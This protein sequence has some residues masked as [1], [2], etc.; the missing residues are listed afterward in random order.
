MLGF[1]GVLLYLGVET[2]EFLFLLQSVAEER[3]ENGCL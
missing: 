3:N 2:Y 1:V